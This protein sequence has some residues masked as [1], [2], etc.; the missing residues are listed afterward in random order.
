VAPQISV[1]DV[2]EAARQGFKTIINN[3]PD[4]E[5]P[6]QPR[7]RDLQ[8]AAQAA[9]LVYRSIAFRGMDARPE[10]ARAL[11]ELVSASAGPVLAFC[12][13]GMRSTVLWAGMKVGHGRSFDEVAAPAMAAGYDLGKRRSVVQSLAGTAA[14]STGRAAWTRASFYWPHAVV[15]LT[16]LAVIYLLMS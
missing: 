5:A 2:A 14:P 7:D 16:L 12:Q 11:A 1:A 3:R 10:Q 13:S 9:G 6:D 4:G 8:E 15:L